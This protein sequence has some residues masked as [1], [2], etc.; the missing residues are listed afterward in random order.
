MGMKLRTPDIV[1]ACCSACMEKVS[2]GYGHS[3]EAHEQMHE[4]TLGCGIA[5][6]RKYVSERYLLQEFA[7]IPSKRINYY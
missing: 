3:T 6:V 2:L 1:L 7:E 4:K 5:D